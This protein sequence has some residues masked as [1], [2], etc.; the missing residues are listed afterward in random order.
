V[1]RPLTV[2]PA[3]QEGSTFPFGKPSWEGATP[4]TRPLLAGGAVPL[5]ALSVLVMSSLSLHVALSTEVA[6]GPEM[7]PMVT[8]AA[9]SPPASPPVVPPCR[10][11]RPEVGH[12][13]S[14]PS[15]TGPRDGAGLPPL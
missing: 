10:R 12:T 7:V 9:V 2:V 13:Y 14:R 6:P 3:S 1:D 15:L 4:L 5:T 11:G 8:E